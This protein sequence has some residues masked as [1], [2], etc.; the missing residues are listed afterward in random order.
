MDAVR[1]PG[2]R[3]VYELFRPHLARW[4]VALG[5]EAFLEYWFSA[6]KENKEM[7]AYARQLK[8]NG[9]K[10]FVLSNNFRERTEYYGRTFGFLKDFDGVFYSWQTGLVKP[11]EECWRAIAAKHGLNPGNCHYFDDSE[12]NVAAAAKTGM[13]AH[14]Y[15]GL[16]DAKA[17]LEGRRK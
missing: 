17:T 9:W 2:A 4:G 1:R 12:K 14:H 6:E 16:E 5:E 11:D 8:A 10:L 15:T 3:P 13:S 7:T